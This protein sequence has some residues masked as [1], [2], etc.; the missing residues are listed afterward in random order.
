M[1]GLTSGFAVATNIIAGRPSCTRYDEHFRT[2]QLER[3]E[4]AVADW[5]TKAEV[6]HGRV[7][8]NLRA[9]M[10]SAVVRRGV[11]PATINAKAEQRLE[12]SLRQQYDRNLHHIIYYSVYD[13]HDKY[14]VELQE[15]LAVPFTERKKT[16]LR[17]WHDK[18]CR[19][20][21]DRCRFYT[22]TAALLFSRPGFGKQGC[23]YWF[24][25]SVDEQILVESFV[26]DNVAPKNS[27]VSTSLGPPVPN[28]D[29]RLPINTYNPGRNRLPFF[30]SL[31][32]GNLVYGPPIAPGSPVTAFNRRVR[33]FIPAPHNAISH[34]SPSE[35]VAFFLQCHFP[36]AGIIDSRFDGPSFLA[37][38]GGLQAEEICTDPFPNGLGLTMHM[39]KV[40]LPAEV[41]AYE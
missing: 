25:L 16:V 29:D 15:K 17:D 7:H 11:T 2:A 34:W 21:L 22:N 20:E 27:D 32:A 12:Q 36:L 5:T 39:F 14:M 31:A 13:E 33:T 4:K 38:L 24:D 35:L 6:E 23:V 3:R 30:Q 9:L 19:G 1:L 10:Y 37:M 26:E 18:F 8:P 40:E 28:I 41:R